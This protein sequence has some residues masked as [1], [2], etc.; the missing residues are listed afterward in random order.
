MRALAIVGIVI[1][2]VLAAAALFPN[3]HQE[4]D[5]QTD[6]LVL[7][8]QSNA[9]YRP[10]A[11]DPSAVTDFPAP[12]TAY[13]YGTASRPAR[14]SDDPA[15][16]GIMPMSTASGATIGDKWP[17]LAAAYVEATGHRILMMACAV[18]GVGIDTFDPTDPFPNYF[19]DTKRMLPEALEKAE[20]YGLKI[21]KIHVLWIQGEHDRAM[22][23]ETYEGK[24]KTLA[25]A[26]VN[27]GLGEPVQNPM[28]VCKVRASYAPTI[29]EAQKELCERSPGLCRMASELADN[30][31]DD[32]GDMMPDNIHYSQQGNE[33][34]GR[35]CGEAIGSFAAKSGKRTDTIALAASAG[36]IIVIAFGAVATLRRG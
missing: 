31:A 20:A 16:C 19:D 18:G 29:A 14:F 35:S 21:G 26:I 1:V 9:W 36:I 27:G 7:M 8:G 6:V 11:A 25:T 12:G 22:S 30:F 34:L 4:S 15:E 23:A 13:Y 2:I 5:D 3:L 28:W 10:I 24:L 33:K 32:S 17:S